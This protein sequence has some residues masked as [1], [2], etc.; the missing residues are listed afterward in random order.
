ML[1]N[2]MSVV[3]ITKTFHV[4]LDLA[5]LREM[6]SQQYLLTQFNLILLVYHMQFKTSKMGSMSFQVRHIII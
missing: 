4:D 3:C 1:D 2:S 6:C 5:C